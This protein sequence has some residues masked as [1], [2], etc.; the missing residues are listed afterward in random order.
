MYEPLAN[1]YVDLSA[2]GFVDN[3]TIGYDAETGK[4]LISVFNKSHYQYH[5]IIDLKEIFGSHIHLCGG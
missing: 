5:T 3:L 2:R 1:K 4:L